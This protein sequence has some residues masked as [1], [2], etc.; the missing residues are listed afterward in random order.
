MVKKNPGVF[1]EGHKVLFLHTGGALG[2]Y[3]K[4]EEVARLMAK[5]EK[6]INVVSM[7]VRLPSEA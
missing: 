7:D 4:H 6:G 5:Q 3:D 2:L 1:Q